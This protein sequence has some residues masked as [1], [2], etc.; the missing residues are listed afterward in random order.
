MQ[1]KFSKMI[2]LYEEEL[3]VGG[4]ADNQTVETISKR[5]NVDVKLIEAQLKAGIKVEH[6][7]ALDAKK[8]EEIAKDHLWEDPH[9]YDKLEKM[10]QTFPK[11]N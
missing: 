9:Y 10:E 3:L 4:L 1:D 11:I 2:S 7:H 5:H 6:E 8:A